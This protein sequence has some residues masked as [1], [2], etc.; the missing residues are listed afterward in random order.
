MAGM[1]KIVSFISDK[2]LSHWGHTSTIWWFPILLSQ[3]WRWVNPET[4]PWLYRQAHVGGRYYRKSWNKQLQFGCR[5]FECQEKKPLKNPYT[6]FFLFQHQSVNPDLRC[7][8]RK[9]LSA[10]LF[11]WFMPQGTDRKMKTGTRLNCCSSNLLVY[12]LRPRIWRWGCSGDQVR[13]GLSWTW[14]WFDWCYSQANDLI[15]NRMNSVATYNY[16]LVQ[17][18][19]HRNKKL[20]VERRIENCKQ[21][22]AQGKETLKTTV[23]TKTEM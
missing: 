8:A 3:R 19:S 5:E 17:K 22:I 16:G 1:W 2:C 15:C 13:G 21:N 4:E 9:K 7:Q 18:L 6:C 20:G 12:S 11:V 23:C 10:S 14:P